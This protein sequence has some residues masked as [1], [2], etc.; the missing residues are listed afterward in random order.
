M[1][2][3]VTQFLN[4]RIF[5]YIGMIAFVFFV[6]LGCCGFVEK[7]AEKNTKAVY[8]E[9]YE[10]GYIQGFRKARSYEVKDTA[11]LNHLYPNLDLLKKY[12]PMDTFFIK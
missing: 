3:K 8:N 11:V 4:S 10:K 2:N 6:I 7:L 1:I 12:E 5:T 9:I